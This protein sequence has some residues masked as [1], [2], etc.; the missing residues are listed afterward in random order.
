MK[1]HLYFSGKLVLMVL[2]LFVFL[3]GSCL[4]T[5]DTSIDEGCKSDQD[6]P[7]PTRQTCKVELGICVGHTSPLG[8]VDASVEDG[9][10]DGD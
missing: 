7:V 5:E 4:E 3:I 10:I 1:K 8:D 2:F 9:G 6:C